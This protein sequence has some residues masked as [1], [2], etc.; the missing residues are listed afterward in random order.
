MTRG[1]LIGFLSL[2]V[3]IQGTSWAQRPSRPTLSVMNLM[4]AGGFTA[5]ET[6]LLTDRLLVELTRTERF[7][8][9]ERSRRDEI[10]KEQA[11]QQ[12]GVCDEAV[13]LVQVGKLLGVQK[14]V[15]GTIGR[16]GETFS[17]N[18][19]MVDV[20]TGRIEQTAVRDFT[21]SQEYLLTTALREVAW[22]LKPGGLTKDDEEELARRM[23]AEKKKR[24]EAENLEKEREGRRR[25][26]V[27]E[28]R[29][30]EE[31][32]K[33]DILGKATHSRKVKRIA[34]LTTFALGGMAIAGGLYK[35]DQASTLYEKYQAT[36]DGATADQYEKLV[37]RA[38]LM[39]NISY[40]T[41]GL[42]FI[43]SYNFL[44]SSRRKSG[45]V[46]K[47]ETPSIYLGINR[48]GL[49]MAVLAFNF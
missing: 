34:A 32:R 12:S 28:Q 9:T 15:G 24:E 19:R 47:M 5:E 40:G 35:W 42:L 36:T 30:V 21:G 27:E 6:V 18:L 22:Q 4:S 46:G 44:S 43:V 45:E 20:E 14:M 37:R 3:A 2:F 11:F 23:L 8:I 16:F 29:L 38:D 41:G 31:R 13:C 26:E 48:K 39:A 7:D 33:K 17:V 49:P 10:L 1:A 25:K